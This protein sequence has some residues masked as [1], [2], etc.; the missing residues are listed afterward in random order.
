[1]FFAAE[2]LQTPSIVGLTP[3]NRHSHHQQYTTMKPSRSAD[4]LGSK[5]ME[6]DQMSLSIHWI[7]HPSPYTLLKT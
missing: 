1:M 6:Q 4:L 5:H 7:L 2:P 3:T